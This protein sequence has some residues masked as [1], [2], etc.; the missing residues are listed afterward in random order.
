MKSKKNVINEWMLLSR[1]T[2]RYRKQTGNNQ[3]EGCEKEHDKGRGL[4]GTNYYI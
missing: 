1:N 3:W 4:R 2:N